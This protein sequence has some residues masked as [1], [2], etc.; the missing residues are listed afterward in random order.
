MAAP[1]KKDPRTETMRFRVT[2]REKASIAARA[3]EAG[4]VLSDYLRLRALG[5]KPVGPGAVLGS[6]PS[7]SI[8]VEKAEPTVDPA[9]AHE[10]EAEVDEAMKDDPAA[11]EAFITRRTM[12]L[13]GRHTL[14]IAR[15][16]AEK[17][18]AER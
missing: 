14:P 1:K 10:V 2:P 9:V 16:M 8:E 17:E 18:W 11:H 4:V 7:P 12:Q 5:V 13:R 15:R 3:I 6:P